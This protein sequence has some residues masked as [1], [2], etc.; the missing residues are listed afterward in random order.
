MDEKD[1]QYVL[2]RHLFRKKNMH[3]KREYVLSRKN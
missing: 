1:I 2:G 3:T